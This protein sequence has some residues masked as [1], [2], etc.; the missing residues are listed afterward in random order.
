VVNVPPVGTEV[1]PWVGSYLLIAFGALAFA[2]GVGLDDL[3]AQLSSRSFSWLQPASV[4]AGIAVGL[5]TLT[6]AAWWVWSGAS[7]PIA[8]VRL[9]AIPPY[10]LNAAEDGTRVLAID[11]SGGEA[12][13]SVIDDDQIRL[14]DADRGFTFGGSRTAPAEASDLVVRLVAGTA[15]SDLAP[16]LAEL[17]IG[18]LWVSGADSDEQARID[19]TPGLGTA[20]GNER[21]IVWQLDPPVSRAAVVDHGS[22]TPLNAGGGTVPAGA[23]GRQLLTGE[24]ADPRWEAKLH[25]HPLPASTAG[26]QQAF[27]LPAQGGS[28][29]WMLHTPW[30]WLSL[31]QLAALLVASVL[32]APAIRR[33]EVRDP[34]KSARR[35]AIGTE[36]AE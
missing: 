11:L 18:Y 21:G 7:G 31:G 13:Y 35:A 14:G 1:R 2:G 23:D 30:R 34:T 26:W 20:S 4:L 17:G 3:P 12:R 19:N 28:V 6:G 9:N 29:S 24:P 33:P 27:V 16:Q 25:G 10:V 15:D 8:R 32:A 36:V 22:R 5:I